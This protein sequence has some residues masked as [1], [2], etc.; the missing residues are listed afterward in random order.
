MQVLDN[1]DEELPSYSDAA[2]AYALSLADERPPASR[3]LLPEF[4]RG[5]N[6]GG[7]PQVSSPLH[8][9]GQRNARGASQSPYAQ[10]VSRAGSHPLDQYGQPVQH[11]G[12]AIPLQQSS[13]A[14]AYSPGKSL[15]YMGN[16]PLPNQQAQ[17]QRLAPYYHPQDLPGAWQGGQHF[18]APRPPLHPQNLQQQRMYPQE[19]QFQQQPDG[20]WQPTLV[21][22]HSSLS[23]I[24]SQSP[25]S[26]ANLNHYQ[27]ASFDPSER[28]RSWMQ[29]S[30]VP[31]RPHMQHHPAH[32]PQTA[33]AAE[34]SSH[35][36]PRI[37]SPF[38]EPSLAM[39]QHDTAPNTELLLPQ[40]AVLKPYRPHDDQLVAEAQRAVEELSHLMAQGSPSEATTTNA[41]DAMA[42]QSL[43]SNRTPVGDDSSLAME[44][45]RP[46]LPG[47]PLVM[48]HQPQA[49][50]TT[51]SYQVASRCVRLLFSSVILIPCCR[52]VCLSVTRDL[53]MNPN[54]EPATLAV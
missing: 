45:Q 12:F 13:S 3:Q 32:Q 6:A 54:I 49:R 37:T 11:L 50:A 31:A 43:S 27:T 52:F 46:S 22:P 33:A 30:D 53:R 16:Q 38:N 42:A 28:V 9:A 35:T 21:Q 34:A 51:N 1:D 26:P 15:S 14:V 10:G 8:D 2:M 36:T 39:H 23:T 18:T 5:W 19:G 41:S 20:S 25:L 40:R 44:Q 17:P 29:A 24:R 4:P 47:H 7:I 48:Q